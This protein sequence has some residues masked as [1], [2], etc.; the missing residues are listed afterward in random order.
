MGG[1]LF[2]ESIGA[3]MEHHNI[4]WPS[5]TT[6]LHRSGS[7]LALVLACCLMTP[8]VIVLELLVKEIIGTQLQHISYQTTGTQG[9]MIWDEYLIALCD[10]ELK[11]AEY[12]YF[13]FILRLFP[14]AWHIVHLSYV[15][16]NPQNSRLFWVGGHISSGNQCNAVGS[17]KS[18]TFQGPIYF[19]L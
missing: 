19:V 8:K 10:V 16:M 2:T 7:P 4:M 15:S 3:E 14:L 17:R 6:C 9:T 5:N 13:V 18:E 1:G 11:N 12:T